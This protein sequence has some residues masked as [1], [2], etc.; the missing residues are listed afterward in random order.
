[1]T[2]RFSYEWI[3]LNST[4]FADWS[5]RPSSRKSNSCPHCKLGTMDLVGN[6]FHRQTDSYYR[7]LR[8]AL[9]EVN[10]TADLTTTTTATSAASSSSSSSTTSTSKEEKLSLST[11]QSNKL[12]TLRKE[13]ADKAAASNNSTTA[14]EITVDSMEY[15]CMYCKQM[16]D[17]PNT[18]IKH[19]FRC[20]DR[21]FP[22]TLGFT[23]GNMG[24]DGCLPDKN[25]KIVTIGWQKE[26]THDCDQYGCTHCSKYHIC[27]TAGCTI[28]Q[29]D[30][31]SLHCRPFCQSISKVVIHEK[32]DL[33]F[34]CTLRTCT[35]RKK[36]IICRDPYLITGWLGRLN[37]AFQRHMFSCTAKFDCADCTD[38]FREE[39]VS[40][41]GL[42]YNL[43]VCEVP[44]HALDHRAFAQTRAVLHRIATIVPAIWPTRH[45][46]TL[47]RN[48]P[49]VNR[50]NAMQMT[51]LSAQL[52]DVITVMCG[53][54][55]E[56]APPSVNI[57]PPPPPGV[58][59]A[60]IS[61]VE[62]DVE[63]DVDAG[64]A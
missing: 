58:A 34:N 45:H 53:M 43:P 22:C 50:A 44:G 1:M 60:S 16:F 13:V 26:F 9:S 51:A 56:A 11:D 48:G 29:H 62:S 36:D 24:G 57:P 12:K 3:G 40:G 55:P 4:K 6:H 35:D 28:P 37:H 27:N 5:I 41:G 61:L 47:R 64:D 42:N 63:S 17:E 31:V 25:G 2:A 21:T 46:R 8:D 52:E 32:D 49:H 10:N 30:C 20:S 38:V 15:K 59:A 14:G 19:T 7:E 18:L 23:F 54:W 39:P 33:L